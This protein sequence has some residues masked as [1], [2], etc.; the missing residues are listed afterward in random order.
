MSAHRYGTWIPGD[1]AR[2]AELELWMERLWKVYSSRNCLNEIKPD[3]SRPI[4]FQEFCN[5][6]D[7]LAD[8]SDDAKRACA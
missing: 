7:H 4:L 2:D 3:L 6:L 1:S 8:I 5:A